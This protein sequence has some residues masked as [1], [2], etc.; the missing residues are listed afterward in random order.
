M[1]KGVGGQGPR[2][3]APP[4]LGA[5]PYECT[6]PEETEAAQAHQRSQRVRLKS[7]DSISFNCSHWQR[8]SLPASSAGQNPG[9][10]G[11]S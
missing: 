3:R 9:Q 5:W 2:A 1:E 4:R 8:E 11:N 6:Q 10:I 7:Q